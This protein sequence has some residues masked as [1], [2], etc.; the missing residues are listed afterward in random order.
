MSLFNL[1]HT[2][3][4]KRAH[5]L[6]MTIIFCLQQL[7]NRVSS[8][9]INIAFT[10]TKRGFKCSFFM[11][12]FESINGFRRTS[13]EL[14]GAQSNRVATQRQRRSEMKAIGQLYTKELNCGSR[15]ISLL[16]IKL[17]GWLGGCLAVY[18]LLLKLEPLLIHKKIPKYMQWR[19]PLATSIES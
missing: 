15:H 14:L 3:K 9:T 2:T 1:R 17:I 8:F 13:A 4:L 19:S 7:N 10:N 6:Y 11:K 18:W 12:Q 16:W 5:H